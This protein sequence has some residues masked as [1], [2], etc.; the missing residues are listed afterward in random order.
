VSNRQVLTLPPLHA[1]QVDADALKCKILV[2]PCGR[3][4]GKSRYLIH[5][6]FRNG[7]VG[8]RS[9]IVEPTYKIGEPVWGLIE[10]L[11]SS[12]KALHVPVEINRSSRSVQFPLSGGEY[13]MR[14]ADDPESLVA[15][16]LDEVQL[17][18][19]GLH[20][21]KVFDE[22]LQPTLLDRDGLTVIAGVPKGTRGLLYEAR[23][24]AIAGHGGYGLKTA[25][26][27]DNPTLP[28]SVLEDL[29][30]R[31]ARGEIPERYFR[32]EY[33]GE[34]LPVEG[35]V[36]R[37]VLECATAV[38]REA[39]E[40]GR[41]YV[42]GVDWGKRHDFT[43]FS[44]WDVESREQVYL[45]KFRVEYVHAKQRLMALND[46]WHPS[47]IV[48]ET[49]SVGDPIIEEL[50]RTEMPIVRFTTT[51]ESKQTAIDALALAFEQQ[52]L[53]ILLDQDQI[54][55]LQAFEA[56]TL[57]SGRTRYAAPK[58]SEHFDDIVM[59]DAFA[60]SAIADGLSDIVVLRG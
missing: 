4:W 50:E 22:S 7:W 24:R 32:Q 54:A 59:A 41:R 15:E 13:R 34:F 42:V 40:A 56:T 44:L 18:E 27:F 60:W 11:V 55:Q 36:F 35:E 46:K 30:E 8:K 28:A 52:S 53:K 16:G 5:R 45:D 39:P 3:R 31:H 6:G 19:A 21:T 12:M 43:V 25:T 57:P 37:H 9:W 38:S 23:N 1:G 10:R 51:N 17:D 29:R 58:G 2:L 49:A 26:T 14:S 48:I 47:E 33:M 20:V